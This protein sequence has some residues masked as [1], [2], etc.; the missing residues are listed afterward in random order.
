MLPTTDLGEITCT[1]PKGFLQLESGWA[2]Q[3]QVL[4]SP[5]PALVSIIDKKQNKN[6]LQTKVT[7]SSILL[8]KKPKSR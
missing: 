4:C 8:L 7:D 5:Y 2:Q 3:T 1:I 6:L